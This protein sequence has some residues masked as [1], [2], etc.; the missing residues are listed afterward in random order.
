[1]T[2]LK[3]GEESAVVP[4]NNEI[5]HENANVEDAVVEV[6]PGQQVFKNL[7]ILPPLQKEKASKDRSNNE[8]ND[9]VPLPPIRAEEP[10]SSIRAA[11]GEIC[12]YAHLT[13]YRFVLE[14]GD[15]KDTAAASSGNKN[16]SSSSSSQPRKP[17]PVASPY[18]GIDAVISTKEVVKSFL[19]EID[20]TTASNETD[21]EKA[22]VLDE[23]GDLTSLLSDDGLKDGSGFRI[24]LER[25]DIALIRD[26]IARLR[27]LLDGNAPNSVSLDE[28]GG[29]ATTQTSDQNQ[30]K[31]TAPDKDMPVFLPDKPLS[32]DI[33]DLKK[34]F[35]YACGEDPALYLEDS[36]AN[37]KDTPALGGA[38]GGGKS[39]K[40]GKKKN[41]KAS[42][43]QADKADD[44]E[45]ET[46]EQF[47]RRIIPLL[48]EIEERTRV[49]CNIR[50][51]GFHPPP[52]FRQFM[53]DLAYLEVTLPDGEIVSISAT[54]LGFFVNRSSLS[55][56]NYKFNPSPAE[57]P[58]FS[59][60]L[61]D[62]LLQYSKSF[63]DA[64][65]DALV[66]AKSRAELMTKVNEDGPFHSFFRVAIRGDFPGYK[67]PSVA[68]AC[69]GID[70]LVQTP[71]WLVPI[72]K[73]EE[74]A[75]NA[76]NRNCEHAYSAAKTE[77]DVSNSYGVDIRNGSLRDW[78]EELQVA[79]EMPMDNLLER[80]ERARVLNKVLT[81]F[82]EA[83]ILGV[84]AIS[85]GQVT[86]MNP[87]EPLRSQVFLHNN[88]FFSRAVDAGLETF[89][90][91]KGDKAARKSASRDLHCLGAIHRM[92]RTGL[93]T[94]ATAVVDYIGSRFVCQSILPGIL[95]GEKT[96]T[97][98]YGAV[99]S[100]VPLVWD[101]EMHDVFETTLGKGLMIA[102][103]PM[104]KQ[105]LTPERL[106]EI[107]EAKID[108]LAIRYGNDDE[109]KKNDDDDSKTIN[110]CA[111]LEAKGIR[112]SDQRKYVL[113]MTR[114]TPRDANWLPKEK[115]GTGKWDADVE[116]NGS[117]SNDELIPKSLDDEEW[118]LAVLRN[119]LVSHF[120]QMKMA[121]Y[122]HEKRAAAEQEKKSS[123]EQNENADEG[124]K[125][126]ATDESNDDNK[127]EKPSETDPAE[128]KKM[129]EDDLAYLSSLRFN[130]NVFLPDIITLEGIDDDAFEK[131]K[132][133]EELVRE[134]ATYLWDDVIPGVTK[135]IRMGTVHTVPHDGKSLT[136]FIHQRGINCRYLGQL[137]KLA[138]VEE[139]KDKKQIKG[140]KESKVSKLDRRKMPLFWL[141]LLECEM[142]ARA[143]KHVLDRY[144]SVNNYANCGSLS[145]IVASFLC[146][147]V[148]EGEETAAQTEKRLS[149]VAGSEPDEDDLAA[150]TLFQTGGSVC[151]LKGR[152]EV[153]SEIETEIGRRFRYSLTIFNQSSANRR[154][155]YLPLLRRVCQRNGIRLV[156]KSYDI[157]AKCIC[158]DPGS[159]GSIIPS[160]P[161]SALD[162]V[163]IVPLMKHA[164]AHNEGFVPCGVVPT[165]GLPPLHISLPDARA[166]LEQAHLY[167]N[168][169]KLSRA[170]DLAQEAAGL[171]QRVSETPAHPGVVRCIDL[172]ASILY[173]AGEPAL[174]AQNAGKA[175]GYQTQIS[176]FDSPDVI[177]L[178]FVMFQFLLATGEPS[179]AVKHIKAAIY[180]MELIGGKNHL[181]LS[182]AYH[183]A[184]TVYHGVS[185]LKTAL[186]FYQEATARDSCDRLLEAMISKSSAL[187]LAG[188]GDF[189]EAVYNEQRAL[190][191]FSVLLG[192]N[193]TLTKQSD[194]ALKNFMRA[195]VEHGSRMVSDLK[196]KQEE[197][198]A[199]A[200]AFEIEAEEAAEEARRK[201]KNQKKKKGKKH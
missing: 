144:L 106:L 161:I 120:A 21:A 72:P 165:T 76:W 45:E 22:M 187:V 126:N 140:Y 69:E 109:E 93:H 12:G 171:Y 64:W 174:A 198:A 180:L 200:I 24:V 61:L 105:P 67:R 11:L 177:N 133:D 134:A 97:L 142:V 35:Y 53:G 16:G 98:L 155:L 121:K 46:K 137:A 139:E 192:A 26:H 159:G 185:D 169:R 23:F 100:G 73:V 62:C 10:V 32:P 19:G 6:D 191:L 91:A 112:G 59:H 108:T 68:A 44:V 156:A 83:V 56:G 145:Q 118:T 113:D 138:Q 65:S 77:E 34:F 30:K 107:E 110:L 74:E 102:T 196:K 166:T 33:N 94:L 13:N 87:N 18:T 90:V 178:H 147:L 188:V 75:N 39:K 85:Q 20:P 201:K 37:K 176:G 158:S 52:Q 173:D 54:P 40:K 172:I 8:S 194:Q 41:S 55:T 92:E 36:D 135:E 183:K 115:G 101:K 84:K 99:E 9:A 186:R 104:P 28:S 14:N 130:V 86:P 123:A 58:C 150:L 88:I 119:E 116:A 89:K 193:H 60:E 27:T 43:E 164:A 81:D 25:Y 143:S 129:S 7:V 162:V 179:K 78:N 3:N 96:H 29:D 50:F 148:S 190:Q 31:D 70:A 163:D 95:S 111:P 1:M 131:I 79:R 199:E 114:L 132:K 157:G 160:Y 182:N 103:R 51:S 136:E 66:A 124:D 117:S 71:S 49:S 125:K 153:W 82:G 152:Q 149:K 175:L 189:K 42:G 5:E 17:G 2:D 80:I 63:S 38:G 154:A 197:E 167:H 127:D 184:G 57:K 181:E 195:A 128:R 15:E 4:T 141:E 146:A 47:M 170:L 48:N 168:K 151:P 122:V